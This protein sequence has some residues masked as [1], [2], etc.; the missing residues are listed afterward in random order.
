[1]N[2]QIRT[3]T[4]KVI[5]K[6]YV[7]LMKEDVLGVV[8]RGHIFVETILNHLLDELVLLN[9]HLPSLRFEQKVKLCASLGMRLEIVEPL[10]ELG[11]IRNAFSHNMEISLNKTMVNKFFDKFSDKDKIKLESSIRVGF[12]VQESDVPDIIPRMN[13]KHLFVALILVLWSDLER[14]TNNLSRQK[15]LKNEKVFRKSKA[16]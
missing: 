14:E 10:K 5:S 12:E 2:T 4:E 13:P 8:I 15:T 6:L 3:S 9:E 16:G 7:E 11:N 1:M